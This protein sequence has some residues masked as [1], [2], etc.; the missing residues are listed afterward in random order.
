MAI[1]VIKKLP[2]V[3]WIDFEYP[4]V[5]IDVSRNLILSINPIIVN[6]KEVKHGLK[7]TAA[8]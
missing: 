1:F 2:L 4:L 7:I 5:K 6:E 8:D 3:S